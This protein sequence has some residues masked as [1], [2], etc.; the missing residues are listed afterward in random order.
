MDPA[1]MQKMQEMDRK[2]Q[3]T[4]RALEEERKAAQQFMSMAAESGGG[5]GVDA[6]ALI[7]AMQKQMTEKFAEQQKSMEA[8]MAQIAAAA[9]ASGGGMKRSGLTYAEINAKLAELQAQLFDP[10]TDERTQEQLNIEYEKLITELEST[11]EYKEEQVAIRE[12][13]KKENEPLNQQA[14]LEVRQGMRSMGDSGVL[15]LLKT[16]PELKLVLRTPDQLLKLHERDFTSLTTQNLTL[17]EAR[18]LYAAMPSFRKEQEKQ[19]QWVDSLKNKIENEMTKPAKAP[20]PPIAPK[21]AVKLPKAPKKAAAG[22]GGDFLQ[23]LLAKRS[24]K[25]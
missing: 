14:L 6:T 17:Q 2:L 10:N 12:R 13:W 16:K 18:A 5:G 9:A 15:E 4:Q 3:E 1:M 7:M 8:R 20:P 22:G 25:E 24:R 23:E 11:T 19:V 21:K